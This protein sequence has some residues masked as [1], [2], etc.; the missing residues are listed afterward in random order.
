MLPH[1]VFSRISALTVPFSLTREAVTK[2]W[3]HFH[4]AMSVAPPD[5]SVSFVPSSAVKVKVSL[6]VSYFT[7]WTAGS[8]LLFRAS[9]QPSNF[10]PSFAVV[11]SF[12]S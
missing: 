8:T 4:W 12:E 6:A 10:Q 9:S 11:A 5:L 2:R 7:V 3:R 1:S